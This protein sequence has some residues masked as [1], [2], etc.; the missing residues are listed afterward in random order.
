MGTFYIMKHAL[1]KKHPFANMEL[2]APT[3]LITKHEMLRV[4]VFQ[5]DLLQLVKLGKK[6]KIMFNTLP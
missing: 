2:V 5:N 3:H 6:Y 4:S 1:P